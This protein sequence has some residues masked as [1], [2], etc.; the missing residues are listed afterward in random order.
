MKEIFFSNLNDERSVFFFTEDT[1]ADHQE[2]VRHQHQ[3]GRDRS[4][5]KNATIFLLK[6]KTIF[7]KKSRNFNNNKGM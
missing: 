5:K 3:I 2:K 1:D 6:R 4:R 7:W